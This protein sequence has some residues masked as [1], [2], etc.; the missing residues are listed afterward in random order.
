[1]MERRHEPH[2]GVITL[3]RV[4]NY[5]SALQTF[6][7]QHLLDRLGLTNVILD[8]RRPSEYPS[9]EAQMQHNQR[10]WNRNEITRNIY[11]AVGWR[12]YERREALFDEF[13][14]NY[15]RL[16][17][18]VASLEEL[19][20]VVEQLGISELIVG[21]DQVW[22]THYNTAGSEPYFLSFGPRTTKKIAFASSFG[23]DALSAEQRR[24]VHSFLQDFTS[25]SVREYSAKRLLNQEGIFA[26]CVGDPTIAL[27]A[28][29]WSEQ[30]SLS[31]SVQDEYVLHYQLHRDHSMKRAVSSASAIYR[32]RSISVKG[33]ESLGPDRGISN[34]T[35]SEFLSLISNAR[36]V[37]TD[38]FH[39][40]LFSLIFGIP[41]TVVL[42]PKYSVRL[43]DLARATGTRSRV[44]T[45]D[46][47]TRL[48]SS[49][50][51]IVDRYLAAQRHAQLEF[52]TKAFGV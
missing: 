17:R 26:T 44:M 7:T 40:M 11:R 36:H 30:L 10:R 15:V 16:S 32:C 1:M 6:A 4:H 48:E 3:H 27:N 23:T 8:Y 19:N 38:S 37:V 39:G 52:L 43:L 14:R 41:F 25:V 45:Q 22:N 34:T 28:Q 49:D 47:E 5:G 24:Y 33:F 20:G 51:R 21:S 12:T 9:A 31:Q 46:G 18:P 13:L 29:D 50:S 35:P 2:I 42:P